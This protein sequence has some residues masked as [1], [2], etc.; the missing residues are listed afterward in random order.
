MFWS[1]SHTQRMYCM[2]FLGGSYDSMPVYQIALFPF[3]VF[4]FNL[5]NKYIYRNQQRISYFQEGAQGKILIFQMN[6][7]MARKIVCYNVLLGFSF[8]NSS[9]VS[10]L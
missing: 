9:F 5:I 10:I 8:C 1:V 3:F 2:L 6:V 7:N 4:P